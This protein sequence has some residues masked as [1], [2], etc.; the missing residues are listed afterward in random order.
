MPLANLVKQFAIGD[1]PE[2][3]WI[4][5][6]GWPW[7]VPSGIAP[8]AFAKLAMA[9]GAFLAVDRTNGVQG[10]IGRRHG[11]LTTFSFCGDGP[12]AILNDRIGDG[13]GNYQEKKK[14]QGFAPCETL[15]RRSGHAR[16]EI[17]AHHP[18]S[19]KMREP[20]L[21]AEDQPQQFGIEPDDGDRHDPGNHGGKPGV[22]EFAHP[23][24]AARE[25]D[26]RNDREGELKAEHYLAENEQRRDL[27]LAGDADYQDGRNNGDRAG[28]QPPHPWFEP[29]IQ[30]PFH[31]DLS[32]K[33]TG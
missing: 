9:R 26:Q 28:D 13:S 27:A 24:A 6:I 14:E 7:I 30:E 12:G 4:R 3:V 1:A 5:E 17:F 10:R 21:S 2:L 32:G 31:H 18:H 29:D 25:L 16:R 8:I 15:W 33:C 20:L 19:R 23:G 22:G 11:I